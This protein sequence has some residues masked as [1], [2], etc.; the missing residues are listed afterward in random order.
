MEIRG[1]VIKAA[2]MGQMRLNS[3]NPNDA[4][5]EVQEKIDSANNQLKQERDKA[6]AEVQALFDKATKDGYQA[7]YDKGL[8]Q[9]LSEQEAAYNSRLAEEIRQRT[10]SALAVIQKIGEDLTSRP[11]EW[12]KQ[13]EP[14]AMELVCSIAA[15]VARKLV[16]SDERTI[17]RTL[18]EVLGMV[19]RAPKITAHVHPADLET[20]QMHP[21]GWQSTVGKLGTVEFLPDPN[22]T[23]GGCRIETDHCSIDAGIE[24]QID[25]LLNE[26]ASSADLSSSP[27]PG[28]PAP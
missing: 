17:E 4:M 6:T 14:E 19:A 13:W 20:L 8:Q 12:V 21:E 22:L 9:G 23:R 5:K 2:E 26:I 27:S 11:A 3:F 28:T 7:G 15:R 16:A 18:S 1:R 25:R 10:D 24:T